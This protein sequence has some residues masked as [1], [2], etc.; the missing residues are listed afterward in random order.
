M[1]QN[2]RGAVLQVLRLLYRVYSMQKGFTLIE[3]LLVLTV[4]VFIAIMSLSGFSRFTNDR[5]LD[6]GTLDVITF[7]QIARSRAQSQ[8]KPGTIVACQTAPLVGY[9]VTLCNFPGAFCSTPGGYELRI[10]CGAASSVIAAKKLP[11]GVNFLSTTLGKYQF[12]SINGSSDAGSIVL[13][14]TSGKTKQ[15]DITAMGNINI[16]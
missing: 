10:V 4:S 1:R 14:A 6:N 7:L 15:I 11:L 13:R 3:L 9:E 8:V 5:T 12:R 2:K 16:R